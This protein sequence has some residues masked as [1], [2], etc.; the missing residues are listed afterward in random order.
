MFLVQKWTPTLIS[1]NPPRLVFESQFLCPSGTRLATAWYALVKCA[2]ATCEGAAS[3]SCGAT[4]PRHAAQSTRGRDACAPRRCT[5]A[6]AT[7]TYIFVYAHIKICVCTCAQLCVTPVLSKVN[8]TLR[9]VFEPQHATCGTTFWQ[10]E[11][12]P[13]HTVP[14]LPLSRVAVQAMTTPTSAPQTKSAI[15]WTLLQH[16][17][18]NDSGNALHCA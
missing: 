13:L 5:L 1:A 14:N 4:W 10:P 17:C 11:K 15:I 18:A 3:C 6:A 8:P 9:Y 2:R 12:L 16:S 7:Y